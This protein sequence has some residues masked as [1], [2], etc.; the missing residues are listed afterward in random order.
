MAEALTAAS[1]HP[2]QVLGL[3]QKKGSLN[4]G[5]DADMVLLNSDLEVDA[6]CI[7]GEVVWARPGGKI[8]KQLQQIEHIS[9]SVE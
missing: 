5:C 6:T 9:E 1:L 2:A 3:D 8:S 7:A 4:H